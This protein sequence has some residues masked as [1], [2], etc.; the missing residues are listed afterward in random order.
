[1]LK[2]TTKH[3]IIDTYQKKGFRATVTDGEDES[4]VVKLRRY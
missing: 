3:T 1:M 2:H 4:V